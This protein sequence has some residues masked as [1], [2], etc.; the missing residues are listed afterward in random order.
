MCVICF[1]RYGK[2]LR[3]F[4]S[5]RDA[6]KRKGMLMSRIRSNHGFAL[7][8]LIIVIAIMAILVGITAPMLIRYVEK[9]NVSSDYQLADTIRSG[10][11]YA[12]TDAKVQEDAA[13]QPFLDQMESSTGMD[14]NND[15]SFLSSD[16]VLRE[17]LEATFGFSAEE[18]MG[19]VR[20]AH[21]SGSVCHITTT[22]GIVTVTLTET[23]RTG[24]KDTS[25]GTPENDI[26]V[27]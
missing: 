2:I 7:I 6:H 3:D 16:S 25:S 12:I 11:Q 27:H 23:D 17:S 24:A 18:I 26:T 1:T 20:S 5:L 14:L 15:S 9:T 13:S 21:G 8:E 22:N 4:V 19:Q 10:V